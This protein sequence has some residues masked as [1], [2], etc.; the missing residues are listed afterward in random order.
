MSWRRLTVS[1]AI[2]A[3]VHCNTNQSCMQ[4]PQ[5]DSVTLVTLRR[6][7]RRHIATTN[8]I[9]SLPFSFSILHPHPITMFW[10]LTLDHLSVVT[11]FCCLMN[12][13]TFLLVPLGL[14][15]PPYWFTALSS[16]RAAQLRVSLH[17]LILSRIPQSVICYGR[18]SIGPSNY[19]EFACYQCTKVHW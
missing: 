3:A 13:T 2:V 8:W 1:V 16:C 10:H 4:T 5:P 14:G 18:T 9:Y 11:S 19:P 12:A 17:Q 7:W 15:K 6:R